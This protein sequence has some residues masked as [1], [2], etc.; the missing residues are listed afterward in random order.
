MLAAEL[1]LTVLGLRRDLQNNAIRRKQDTPLPDLERVIELLKRYKEDSMNR[2]ARGLLLIA[3]LLAL[4]VTACTT[5][6]EES[7]EV[8]TP[9]ASS[10][11]ADL[12]DTEIR[13][14]STE[15]IEGYRTAQGMG[16]A[17]PAELNGYPGPRHVLDFADELELSDE[18]LQLI[19]ALF[20]NMQ[21]RAI[22]LGEA[23][24]IAEAELEQAYR[25]GTIS[26]AYLMDKLEEI[27]LLHTQLRYTHLQT[28]LTTIEI[29]TLH[30]VVLYNQLRGYDAMPDDH[31]HA[32]NMHEN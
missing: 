10:G 29:L 19:Q 22:A 17:L 31:Q 11:Y 2:S 27:G 4:V 13:G 3:M 16:M 7:N 21:V 18:Q 12:I 5:K 1:S 30:Q 9:N 6:S 28:H 15:T 32:D 26:E 8:D 20:D 23:I 24:L 14:M 25:D